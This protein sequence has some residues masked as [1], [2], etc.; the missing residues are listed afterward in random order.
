[1]LFNRLPLRGSP[2]LCHT[3]SQRA[4]LRVLRPRGA[5]RLYHEASPLKNDGTEDFMQIYNETTLG[6]EKQQRGRH[7]VS[8]AGIMGD[9]GDQVHNGSVSPYSSITASASAIES[10]RRSLLRFSPH[11]YKV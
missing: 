8:F 3:L 7:L 6:S 9:M 2:A 5:L 1:M 11:L 10:T 4:A